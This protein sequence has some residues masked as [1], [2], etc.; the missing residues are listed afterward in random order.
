MLGYRLKCLF[1]S[2][3]AATRDRDMSQQLIKQVEQH[4]HKVVVETFSPTWNELLTQYRSGDVQ[5]D[6]IYQR[7]FRW[8]VD[9]Q[10]QFIE[11][12][13]L[14]IPTPPIFLAEL[15][16]AKFEVIDGLQRFSTMVRF[17]S[18]EIFDE[19]E[20]SPSGYQVNDLRH[21]TVLERPPILVGLEG[22]SRE[23]LPETL[24]RT[25][26]YARAQVILLK[27]ESSPVAKYNVFM[28]LNRA[29]ATLS[30]Q[31]IRNC[32]ARLFSGT[33]ADMLR[34]FAE[35]K[36]VRDAM[37]M[38]P[39]ERNSMGVEENILRMLAFSHSAIDNKNI[40]ELLDQFMYAASSGEFEV[41]QRHKS[42]VVRTFELLYN[43][44]P[45]GEAF[46]F[47]R[48]DKFTGAFS[49]N[50]FDIVACGVYKNVSAVSK[51]GVEYLRSRIVALHAEVEAIELTGA[52]S[53]TRRKMV[54]RVSFGKTW[55]A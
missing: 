5:I 39:K 13:L 47:Y 4:R 34:E 49:T 26:R 30:D 37:G 53:N 20:I 23:T 50:L 1:L 48:D 27:K 28:R 25:L 42:N 19:G 9:Q 55:F 11:S 12:L 17:F 18:E 14:N 33:F 40:G 45:N 3:E 29:G 52:G 24:L 32:S 21:P 51:R 46:K 6:P 54:G 22:H 41:T 31:E 36:D 43:A 8:T 38:S 15:S 7:G 16:D 35:R 44:Y 2:T 10:S